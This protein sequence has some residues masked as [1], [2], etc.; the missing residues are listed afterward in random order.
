MRKLNPPFQIIMLT[1]GQ[2]FSYITHN[3]TSAPKKQSRYAKKLWC[4]TGTVRYSWFYP[5]AYG[6]RGIY[7]TH[8]LVWNFSAVFEKKIDKSNFSCK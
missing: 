7:S 5:I 6:P 8:C 1:P 4:L 3:W 2:I